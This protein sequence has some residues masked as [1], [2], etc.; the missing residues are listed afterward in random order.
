MDKERRGGQVFSE[1]LAKAIKTC[2]IVVVVCSEL[3]CNSEWVFREVS[4]AIN[5]KKI[6]VPFFIEEFSLPEN[7]SITLRPS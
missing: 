5:N 2:D 6:I 4:F 7:F 1:E 3:S